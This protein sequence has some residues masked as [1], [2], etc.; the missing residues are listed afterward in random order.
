MAMPNMTGVQLA[1]EIKKINSGV[2]IIICTGFSEHL[3]EDRVKA[4]G[5][6]G[7][8]LKPIVSREIAE[9]I[10]KVLGEAKSG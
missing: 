1:G 2:P 6:Q 4:L 7:L 9:V 5:I 10:R 8:V 3:N